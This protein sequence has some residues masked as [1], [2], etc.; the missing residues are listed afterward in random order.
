M[1][2]FDPAPHLEPSRCAVVVF[3]CQQMVLGDD[4]PYRGLADAA[5]DG[6]LDRLAALLEAARRNGAH[7]VYCTMSSREGGLGSPKTPMLDRARAA[8]MTSNASLD[9]SIVPEVAPVEG[10]VI[11]DRTHGMSGFHGTELDPCLRAMGIE[12]VI[13]T[14]VSANLGVLG[15]SIEAVN[16]G[17][18]LVIPSDCIAADPPDYGEQMMRYSYRNLGYVTTSDVVIGVWDGAA[19]GHDPG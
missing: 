19:T 1:N 8:G 9:R 15:T 3:E 18:R 10:D 5:R 16:H 11:V 7:V 14:G 13:P 4:V 17:Y 12:T 2:A 6:M